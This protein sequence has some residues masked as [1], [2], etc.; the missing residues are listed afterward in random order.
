MSVRIGINGFGRMGRLGL[1]AAWEKPGLVCTRI[2]EISTDAAGSAHLPG[3][4][5]EHDTR[6]GTRLHVNS[7]PIAY[8]PHSDIT[9]S[10]TAD[11]CNGD[12]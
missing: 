1:R 8:S 11:R 5:R 3:L 12:V 2:N 10:D 6:D 4:D 7:S 9:G